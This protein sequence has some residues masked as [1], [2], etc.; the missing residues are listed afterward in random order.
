M[1]QIQGIR[2]RSDV[3]DTA[4]LH[5]RF[6]MLSDNAPIITRPVISDTSIASLNLSA[7]VSV[8]KRI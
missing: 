6:V 1:E 2:D 3:N 8:A 7:S 4:D 5:R